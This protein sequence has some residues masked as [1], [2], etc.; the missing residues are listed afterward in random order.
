M[1]ESLFNKVASLKACNFIKKRFQHRRFPVNIEKFLRT[2]I[3]KNICEQLLLG[4][5][6]KM[7]RLTS[8]WHQR[9]SFFHA[10]YCISGIMAGSNR[11]GNLKD[12]QY[13]I[14][15][16]TTAAILTTS[17]V[18]IFSAIRTTRVL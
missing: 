1:L 4:A 3:L 11:S 7:E 9:L 15:R 8:L 12:A 6:M 13:S 18:C 10:S 14:P 5:E 16:G 17:I 2:S